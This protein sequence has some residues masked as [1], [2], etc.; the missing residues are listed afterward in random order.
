MC[1]LQII[2]L[3]RI[4]IARDHIADVPYYC[5][6][7]TRVSSFMCYLISIIYACMVLYIQDNKI[8][9][10]YTLNKNYR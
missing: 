6:S 7:S 8:F 10:Q 1:V 9:V 5:I 4:I 2:F 3:I